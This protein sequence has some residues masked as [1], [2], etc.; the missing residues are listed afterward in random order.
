MKK[1]LSAAVFMFLSLSLFAMDFERAS[2][3]INGYEWGPG[4][5]KVI[6]DAGYEID[7]VDIDTFTLS[8]ITDGSSVE[9][10]AEAVYLSDSAGNKVDA[11][12]RYFSFELSPDSTTSLPFG[13][14][15]DNYF[16]YYWTD[17]SIRLDVNEGNAPYEKGDSWEYEI[18]PND[19]IL[20][21]SSVFSVDS[22]YHEEDGIALNR[23]WYIP[24]T[25]ASGVPLIIWLHD[26]GEGGDDIQYA[27]LG[28][29]AT[30]LTREEIQRHFS[31]SGAAVLLVQTPTYWMDETGTRVENRYLHDDGVQ[32]SFYTEALFAAIEDFVNTHPEVD[33]DRIY[34]GGASNG[35]YMTLRLMFTHGDY[36]AAYFPVC[37]SYLNGNI[38]EE[39]V[40]SSIDKPI[41]FVQAENDTIVPPVIAALPFYYR[42]VAAG[43]ENVH[44]SLFPEVKGTDDPDGIY[45]GHLSWIYLFNDQAGMDFD[46]DKV[47]ENCSD[48][49]LSEDGNLISEDNYVTSSNCNIEGNLFQ[50]L[51]A[52]RRG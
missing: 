16:Q 52:Q 49:I 35:G 31:Q 38:S 12:S 23:A 14:D 32:E 7:D 21:D 25:A 3:V 17:Y 5:S 30:A 22:Y 43:A 47:R 2:I 9:R 10:K 26:G 6:I 34:L 28:T 20:P 36:F 46:I 13:V 24:D 42:L 8:T 51:S 19:R 48:I 18:T 40:L 39:M 44:F 37:E 15:M 11:S 41:W 33:E 50:W 27:L 1:I 29:E 4:V 45:W